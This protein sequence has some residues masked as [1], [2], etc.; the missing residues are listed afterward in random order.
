MTTLVAPP[1]ERVVVLCPGPAAPRRAARHRK[2]F[3]GAVALNDVSVERRGEVHA[4]VGENGAGQVDA[5]QDRR[6]RAAPGRRRA[7][8]DGTPVELAPARRARDGITV[9]AQELALV[10][11]HR[12]RERLP[13]R[14]GAH[15]RG[16]PSRRAPRRYVQLERASGFS[17]PPDARRRA[18]CARRPAEGRDPARARPRRVA[19]SSWTSPRPRSPVTDASCCTASSASSRHPGTPI[20]LVSH[21]L[22]EVLDLCDP[23]TILRDGELITYAPR[24]RTRPSG[25]RRRRCS[26]ARSHRCSPPSRRRPG[27]ARRCSSSAA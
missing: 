18:A 12:G 9:I 27:C 17:L 24:R 22:A 23:V 2:R 6:R 21:F 7:P 13:R 8:V 11:A 26:G 5:R 15:A 3:G 14:R 10:P 4:L 20:V 16:V 1:T 25:P 19:S